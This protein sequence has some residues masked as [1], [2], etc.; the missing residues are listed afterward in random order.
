M[1]SDYERQRLVFIKRLLTQAATLLALGISLR[2]LPHVLPLQN[3]TYLSPIVFLL[4]KKNDVG[5]GGS[6]LQTSLSDFPVTW[7]IYR[8]KCLLRARP[9]CG[10]SEFSSETA[11]EFKL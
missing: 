8:E 3:L 9:T 11:T 2:E 5:G 7:L 1:R 10:A 6:L 4:S